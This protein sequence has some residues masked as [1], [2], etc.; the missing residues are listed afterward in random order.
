M[1]VVSD[2]TPLIALMKASQLDLL[3]KMF[4]KILIPHAVFEELTSNLTF[5]DEAEAVRTSAFIEVV[6]IP[7]KKTVD[8]LR[9]ATG[10]DLGE[11]EAIVYAE[12]SAADILLMDER[13]GRLIASSLGL[14]VMGSIGVLREAHAAG[15]IGADELRSAIETMQDAGI[16]LSERLVQSVL[17][18]LN[19]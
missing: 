18:E 13:K 6:T 8:V 14:P 11:S 4:G 3:Q 19:H 7:D 17:D 2:S 15:M 10:L 9:R 5:Q 12:N 16:R 1:I